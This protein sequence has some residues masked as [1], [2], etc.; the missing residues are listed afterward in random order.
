MLVQMPAT[1]SDKKKAQGDDQT[2]DWRKKKKTTNVAMFLFMEMVAYIYGIGDKKPAEAAKT[3]CHHHI[4]WTPTIIPLN[5]SP[6]S[7][8]PSLSI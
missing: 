2:A 4:Q 5:L 8:N 3:T 6:S 1:A 7:V